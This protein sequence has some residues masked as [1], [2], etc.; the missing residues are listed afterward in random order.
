M[1]PTQVNAQVPSNVALGSQPV[2]VTTP[3]GTSAPYNI[4]V[5]TTQPGL[6][7]PAV[8][9]LAAGQYVGALFSDGVTFALPPGAIAGVPSLRAKPGNVIVFYG[10]GF[11]T[12]TPNIQAG[13]IVSQANQLNG[14]FQVSFAGVP[15][16]V[17]FSGL[18]AGYLGLYQFNVTVPNVP[19]SDAV[20]VTFSLGGT[21]GTQKLIIAISN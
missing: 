19:A 4:T 14:N 15:A 2:I 10:V 17:S 12:V 5:N 16:N 3:G 20:P 21:A 8:F 11:G 18:T 9:N 13:L 7:A 1:S 6:L